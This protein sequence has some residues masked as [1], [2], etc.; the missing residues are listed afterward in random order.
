MNVYNTVLY[1][2]LERPLNTVVICHPNIKNELY[3]GP[4]EQIPKTLFNKEVDARLYEWTVKSL[5][6][7]IH[8]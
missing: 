1:T 6:I 3:H 7:W 4:F 5:R 8:A 2:S